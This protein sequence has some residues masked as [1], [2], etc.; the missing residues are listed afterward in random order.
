MENNPPFRVVQLQHGLISCNRT[1]SCFHVVGSN[2]L[3]M[4]SVL[5]Y[6]FNILEQTQKDN[7]WEVGGF[8]GEL[9]GK[10]PPGPEEHGYC[11][12]RMASLTLPAIVMFF[13]R[14]RAKM[15]CNGM[16]QRR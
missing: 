5:L 13:C 9:N 2:R 8:D 14:V 15:K 12:E 3:Y 10:I 4:C 6:I 7:R 11:A 16:Q 1:P